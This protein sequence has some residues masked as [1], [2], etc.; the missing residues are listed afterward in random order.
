MWENIKQKLYQ[1]NIGRNGVDELGQFTL[2]A[3][4]AFTI[5]AMFGMQPLSLIGTALYVVTLIRMVSKNL[6][7]R[8]E[9]NRRFL[10]ARNTAMTKW[11]QFVLRRKNSKEYKYFRCPQC[12]QIIR[13]KRGSGM[14][15]IVCK[16]CSHEFDKKC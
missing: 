1:F 13:A 9:E 6:P 8:Q 10:R 11:R 2:I 12:H 16:K 15:H 3:G 4:L 14:K 7:A 5:L